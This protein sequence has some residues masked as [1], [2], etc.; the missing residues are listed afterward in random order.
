MLLPLVLLLVVPGA[1]PNEAE[2]LFRQMEAKI[3]KA[4][5][6]ECAFDIKA[7]TQG[8]TDFTGKGTLYFGEG[9]KFRLETSIEE[10][11]KVEKAT[12]I[13]DGAKLAMRADKAPKGPQD[14][15]PFLG[16]FLRA[17]ISR[18]II[19]P[20]L[21]DEQDLTEFKEKDYKL[22]EQC[23]VSDFKFGKKEMVGQQEAQIIEYTL[24]FKK[25]SAHV[26]VWVDTKTKLPI[27]R[28]IA[29]PGNEK[30]G[31]LTENYSNLTVDGKI[32]P[33]RFEL[34]KE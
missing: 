27:K 31:T 1:E 29:I 30:M 11:G 21:L 12:M 20:F 24:T 32:D 33:Q 4:K 13:S 9:N 28:V 34:P 5:T 18:I 22:E 26:S 14:L 23:R 17:G 19:I 6:L 15:P 25:Q 8:K 3:M 2:Q 16:Q 7:G 10:E